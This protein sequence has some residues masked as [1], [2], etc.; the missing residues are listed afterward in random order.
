MNPRMTKSASRDNVNVNIQG[1]NPQNP[2]Q[3]LRAMRISRDGDESNSYGAMSGGHLNSSVSVSQQQSINNVQQ[4]N[5]QQNP[6]QPMSQQNLN[7][8]FRNL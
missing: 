2:N 4:Q 3:S 1:S 5:G 6:L 8:P 7:D